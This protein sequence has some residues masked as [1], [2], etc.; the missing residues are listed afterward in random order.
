MIIAFTFLIVVALVGIIVYAT[1]NPNQKIFNVPDAV[2]PNIP[3]VTVSFSVSPGA[4]PTAS[5]ARRMLRR[6]AASGD[7]A[8][9]GVPSASASGTS[10]GGAR[11][12]TSVFASVLRRG[13]A[14]L[15]GALAGAASPGAER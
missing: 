5:P 11:E 2:K 13:A 3:G 9:D 4:T 7:G 8:A 6:L 15:R 14:G 10:L 12:A 1:L